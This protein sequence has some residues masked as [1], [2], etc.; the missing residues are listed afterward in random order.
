MRADFKRNANYWKDGN[1]HF[2]TVEMLS[3]ID[4]TARTN[5]LTTGELDTMDRAVETSVKRV[6]A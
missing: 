5:A 4:V 1:G 6:A 3:I 2:D